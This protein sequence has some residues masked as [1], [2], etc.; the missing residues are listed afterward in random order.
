MLPLVAIEAFRRSSLIPLSKVAFMSL[1]LM[2]S[3]L[4]IATFQ[5][6]K[7]PIAHSVEKI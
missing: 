1:T 3:Y 7:S 2:E 4:R 5:Q 6:M